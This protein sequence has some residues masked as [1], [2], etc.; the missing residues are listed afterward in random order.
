MKPSVPKD[1]FHSVKA[2]CSQ[3]NSSEAQTETSPRQTSL[4]LLLF[5]CRT[6][7]QA[8]LQISQKNRSA[9]IRVAA[10]TWA[11][12][13]RFFIPHVTKHQ[14]CTPSS[15]AIRPSERHALPILSY[16]V[17]SPTFPDPERGSTDDRHSQALILHFR[18]QNKASHHRYSVF[19][20]RDCRPIWCL[21][22]QITKACRLWSDSCFDCVRH[23]QLLHPIYILPRFTALVASLIKA[24]TKLFVVYGGVG[25]R[26]PIR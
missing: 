14:L 2:E 13:Y 7:N 6:R 26:D 22:A 3:L 1:T 8:E 24:S 23:S 5:Y 9:E 18:A 25:S 10:A 20:V 4:S 11:P 16:P 21:S 17:L 12:H 19:C 15:H